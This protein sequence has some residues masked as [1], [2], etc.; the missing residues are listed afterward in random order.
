MTH[1][2]RLT[3]KKSIVLWSLIFAAL[4]TIGAAV[5]STLT[6]SQPSVFFAFD[7]TPDGER[8]LFGSHHGQVVLWS[9]ANNSFEYY[10]IDGIGEVFH[11]DGRARWTYF[12]CD[13]G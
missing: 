3:L 7:I 10:R 12:R 11:V 5:V 4:I 2:S 9:M 13:W 6:P 8:A 1:P